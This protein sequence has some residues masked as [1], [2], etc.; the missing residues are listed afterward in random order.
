MAQQ[1]PLPARTPPGTTVLCIEDHPVHMDVIEAVLVQFADVR[2][3][4]A[5]NGRDGV[6][7]AQT[8]HPAIVLLDMNLP[9]ISG[10]DVVRELSVLMSLRDL[11]IV[12]L[13]ADS[14]SIDVVKALSLGAHAYWSKPIDGAQVTASLQLLLD[15]IGKLAAP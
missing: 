11:R 4:K 7:L 3:I 1:E 14:F 10:L 15:E 13:T 8:E 2:M 6:V 5:Y 9:D 12:L